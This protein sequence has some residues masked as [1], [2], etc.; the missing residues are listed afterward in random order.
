MKPG[1]LEHIKPLNRALLAA[2][3]P[4][5]DPNRHHPALRAYLRARSALAPSYRMFEI[6]NHRV[7]RTGDGL[8]VPYDAHGLLIVF[9]LG[10]GGQKVI[11]EKKFPH[12]TVFTDRWLFELAGVKGKAVDLQLRIYHLDAGDMDAVQVHRLRLLRSRLQ[13]Q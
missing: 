11:Y 10:P 1:D 7:F 9:L 4:G 13:R 5:G 3:G 12:G 2:W 6:A 8:L